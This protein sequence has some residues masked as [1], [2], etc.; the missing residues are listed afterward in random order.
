MSDNSHI[1]T[2]LINE[3]PDPAYSQYQAVANG[4]IRRAIA[5]GCEHILR[6]M[7][8]MPPKSV[9][10]E[11]RFVYDPNGDGFDKQTRLNL[12]VQI[13]AANK[14]LSKSFDR[15]LRSGLLSRFYSLKKFKDTGFAKKDLPIQCSIV[16]RE[17][18]IQPLYTPN[19][20]H[21]VPDHYYTITS[22]TANE[23][24]DYL[25]LD[26]VLDSVDEPVVI[27]IKVVP[28][29]VSDQLFAH[30]AYLARLGSINRSWDDEYLEDFDSFDY[31]DDRSNRFDS[32]GEKL[33]PLTRRDPLADDLL[34]QQRRFHESL[35][36][37]H[38]HF[39][40]DISTKTEATARL[41]GSVVAESAFSEG[42]YRLVLEN[43]ASEEFTKIE[44]SQ[45]E[46][47]PEYDFL[48]SSGVQ[49]YSELRGLTKAAIV[50][51]LLGIFKFP[52]ASFA[53]PFCIRK[54]TDPEF[55]DPK[56]LIVLGYDQQGQI[57]NDS[58]IPRGVHIDVLKKHLS[59][60]GLPGVGK[61]TCIIN[62]LLQLFQR[63]I[64]FI[65]FESAK[66]EYRVL[67]TFKKHSNKNIRRL[68]KKLRIYSPGNEKVSSFRF[69]PLK[70]PEGTGVDEHI[71]N[72]LACFKASIPVS[73]GSL[74]ALLGEAM[75]RVY[76]RFSDPKKLPV[77]SDLIA[78][79]K[80]VFASKNY[81][82]RMR[83]DI[84]TAIEVRLGVLA[85][86]IIGRVFQC[87]DGVGIEEL[88]QM[89]T[90]IE[91]D[92]L[93]SEQRCLLA[94]FILN[95]ICEVLKTSPAPKG[96][97]RMAIIIEEAHNIFGSK[98]N[99]PAS[100]DIANPKAFIAEFLSKMLVELRALGV[101]IILSDQHP[102]SVDLAATKSVGSKLVFRQT[103][104]VDRDEMAQN[105]LLGDVE[106]QDVARLQTGQAFLFTEGYFGSQRIETVNLH[107]EF[108]L[109]DI[110]SDQELN[111]II[112]DEDW[113]VQ[114]NQ[115]RAVSELIQ[116]K[117]YM[118]Q[119]D[120]K[121]KS[122]SNRVA[123]L[124]SIRN[125]LVRQNKIQPDSMNT[126][127]SSLR[128]KKKELSSCYSDFIRGP[129][130][131]FRYLLKDD[132]EFVEILRRQLNCR[133]HNTIKPLTKGLIK[134]IESEINKTIKL[135][136]RRK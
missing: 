87:K 60:F 109:T 15:L 133:F 74:P 27:R 126:I 5:D 47:S 33:K 84:E 95:A 42:S 88:M 93:V 70:I 46:E 6:T 111:K 61:S 10:A 16:R 67:K 63:N 108:N 7:A 97:I 32:F 35:R 85:E 19:F 64:P 125:K 49:D 54:N 72:L 134:F 119:Y 113:F 104:S 127:I 50:E 44:L 77:M 28:E 124:R 36:Q 66:T 2:Y 118:N 11:L 110:P 96:R 43:T 129:F 115:D 102:S 22:L 122:V 68:A 59:I 41:I 29:D 82:E 106:H 56:D 30:T 37:P 38:L 62:I 57:S 83:A 135:K 45:N 55:V 80:E 131:R 90:G 71:E 121:K 8:N 116:L 112:S 89:W 94:L 31:L 52:I 78:M 24:N 25:T 98:N 18:F 17:D 39:N 132:D 79:V 53:S 4:D 9:S 51:E 92:A 114:S 107:K 103:Y 99:T 48:N 13:S 100:E 21:K 91:L 12:F 76:E 58:P 105:M 101:C 40:I 14:D 65:V 117:E 69:N 86:R 75:E 123:K 120:D 81:S 128:T 20:N 130:K 136:Y 34:R 26:R 23:K 1:L 3:I 73:A